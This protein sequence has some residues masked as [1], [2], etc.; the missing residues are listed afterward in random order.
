[1]VTK[2]ESLKGEW[3]GTVNFILS[4]SYSDE[5]KVGLYVPF[6]IMIRH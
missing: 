3:V 1:M 5:Y 4:F 2:G 6:R